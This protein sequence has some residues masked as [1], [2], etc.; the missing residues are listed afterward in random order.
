MTLPAEKESNQLAERVI[1]LAW[2]VP[3]NSTRFE[4]KSYC[5]LLDS[6]RQ[7]LSENA[8][9]AM[10]YEHTVGTLSATDVRWVSWS[11]SA[12]FY[13]NLF[14]L[15]FSISW[16]CEPGKLGKWT[17]SI[18]IRFSVQPYTW[19]T[20]GHVPNFHAKTTAVKHVWYFCQLYL[21]HPNCDVASSKKV[22]FKPDRNTG[23]NC[24]SFNR[25][26]KETHQSDLVFDRWSARMP[27]WCLI[28]WTTV[29][30]YQEYIA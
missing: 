16:R 7:W 20:F 18:L 14:I 11:S 2:K 21:L 28:C 24:G 17:C 3:Y 6:E 10:K 25:L 1:G 8:C 5:Q 23:V 4:F 9:N 22:K 19:I 27:R 12:A 26:F 13:L 29:I 15:L 30:T